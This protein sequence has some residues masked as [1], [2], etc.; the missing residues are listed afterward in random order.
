MGHK[1]EKLNSFVDQLMVNDSLEQSSK[2]FTDNLMSK[3][4]AISKPMTIVYKPLISK[5]GWIII[6]VAIC[7]LIG[8]VL[9]NEPSSSSRLSEIVDLSKIK[10]NPLSDLSFNFSKTLMYAS[11]LLALMIGVQIP[12][13]KRHFNKQLSI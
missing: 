3:I 6:G 12:L 4:E 7:S 9:F 1:D 2:D 10:M 11:V 8:Y 13:L 5:T